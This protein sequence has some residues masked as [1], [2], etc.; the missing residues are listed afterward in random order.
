MIAA[1]LLRL[2][3]IL[4]PGTMF[5]VDGR[6]ANVRF[7]AHHLYRNWKITHDL[8]GDITVFELQEPPLGEKQRIIL[9]YQL[10]ESFT[11]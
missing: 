5:L 10:R 4:L 1:D 9:K 7:L 3:P 11:E 6:T 8:V 2:E